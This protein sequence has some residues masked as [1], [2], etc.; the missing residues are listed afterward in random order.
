M[1]SERM[2]VYSSAATNKHNSIICEMHWECYWVVPISL[3]A[4]KKRYQASSKNKNTHTHNS[5]HIMCFILLLGKR[6]KR[7]IVFDFRLVIVDS[8]PPVC[9]IYLYN[10]QASG[11]GEVVKLLCTVLISCCYYIT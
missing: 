3:T 6:E 4:G 2:L 1:F 7:R 10:R 5:V 8:V 11:L 9:G